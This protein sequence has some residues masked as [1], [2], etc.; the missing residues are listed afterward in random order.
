VKTDFEG[1]RRVDLGRRSGVQGD[2]GRSVVVST[3]VSTSR[4]PEGEESARE[5]PQMNK[6]QNNEKAAV[7]SGRVRGTS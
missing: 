7:K 2:T 3:I 1:E 4:R 6:Q 5:R